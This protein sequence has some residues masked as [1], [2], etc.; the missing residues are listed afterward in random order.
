[1]MLS[2]TIIFNLIIFVYCVF[3]LFFWQMNYDLRL[4]K[5][6]QKEQLH[7]MDSEKATR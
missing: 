1:M 2:V 7:L 4:Y 5:N 3:W 6:L